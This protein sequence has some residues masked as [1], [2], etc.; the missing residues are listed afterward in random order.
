[1]RYVCTRANRIKQTVCA[2]LELAQLRVGSTAGNGLHPI[3]YRVHARVKGVL[4]KAER[5]PPPEHPAQHTTPSF[6]TA[7]HG[8]HS[9]TAFTLTPGTGWLC[10]VLATAPLANHAAI[11][12]APKP[13]HCPRLPTTLMRAKHFPCTYAH[14]SGGVGELEDNSRN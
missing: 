13:T 6:I 7:L 14:T 1:M 4:Q 10:S 3:P 12:G 9:S 8:I 11:Y 2:R 5:F